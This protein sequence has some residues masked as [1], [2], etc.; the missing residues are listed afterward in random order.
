MSNLELVTV[1]S[2]SWAVMLTS[3]LA[4]DFGR[5]WLNELATRR[6]SNETLT[7]VLTRQ[8]EGEKVLKALA[9]DWRKKFVQLENDWKKLKEHADSQFA[10]AYAQATS[11]QTRGFGR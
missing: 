11:T 8:D 3:M 7:A 2:L 6:A 1:T 5:R 9:E 10:G 4:W